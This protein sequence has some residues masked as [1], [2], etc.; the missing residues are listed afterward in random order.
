MRRLLSSPSGSRIARR[1][2]SPPE[3]LSS[4]AITTSTTRVELIVKLGGSALTDKS[5]HQT[6]HRQRFDCALD[7]IACL[8]KQGIGLIVVHGAGSF[9]HF[10]ASKHNV[11]SG[12]AS[13]FG[14]SETHAAVTRLNG[15][16]VDGLIAREVAAVGVSPLQVP[17]RVRTEFVAALLD[18]GHLPVLHGDACYAGDG[19]TGILS[20]D[21][22]VGS[23]AG[24]FEFVKRVVFL[25]DVPGVLA[26]PP[27]ELNGKGDSNGLLSVSEDAAER[28]LVRRVTVDGRG[29]VWLEAEVRTGVKKHDVTG[30][31]AGK[32]AAAARCVAQGGGR[33]VGFIAG[34]GTDGAECALTGRM[35]EPWCSLKCTRICYEIEVGEDGS[36]GA[37]TGTGTGTGGIG[38]SEASSSSGGSRRR[39]WFPS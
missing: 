36:A 10:E 12:A 6:I 23:L 22:L 5:Q 24:A 34:V 15:L 32:V 11:S 3:I 27:E 1:T 28:E 14:V 8:H 39:N 9:G 21:A 18:R 37:G 2:E 25:S 4:S 29:E 30:G 38:E 19:R 7:T 20:G 26:V 31:I 13:A 35:P 17:G 16:V 33:V